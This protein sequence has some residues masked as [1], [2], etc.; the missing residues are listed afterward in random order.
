MSYLLALVADTDADSDAQKLAGEAQRVGIRN[1][2]DVVTLAELDT[3][4]AY[5]PELDTEDGRPLIAN[6]LRRSTLEAAGVLL[7]AAEGG[8]V[9]PLADSVLTWLA[10]SGSGPAPVIAGKPVAVITAGPGEVINQDIA[11]RL[12]AAGADV[13]ADGVSIA[14]AWSDPNTIERLG[15]VVVAVASS[16]N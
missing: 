16:A 14:T 11:D 9:A 3:L 7:F 6:Q 13:V 12:R 8:V 5:R 15:D 10:H 1:S 4:P 2:V